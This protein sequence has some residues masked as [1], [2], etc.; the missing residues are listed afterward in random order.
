M[1]NAQIRIRPEN[2]TENLRYKGSTNPDQKIKPYVNSQ[3][4]K[5]ITKRTLL[6]RQ[7]TE[8]KQKKAKRQILEP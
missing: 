7:T 2:E 4:K 1:V 5:I 8:E 3:E 6:F